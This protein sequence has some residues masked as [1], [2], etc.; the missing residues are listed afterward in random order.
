[1]Q[2]KYI[3]AYS[4]ISLLAKHRDL[5]DR[6]L[7]ATALSE[8]IAIM[9]ADENFKFYEPRITVIGNDGVLNDNRIPN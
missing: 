5:F 6:L 8:S 2:N 3:E 9:S 7:L 1:L 4:Q